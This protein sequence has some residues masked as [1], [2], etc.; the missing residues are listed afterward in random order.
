MKFSRG[1][2]ASVAAVRA[3]TGA[4]IVWDFTGPDDSADAAEEQRQQRLHEGWEHRQ[5]LLTPSA[6]LIAACALLDVY[7]RRPR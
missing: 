7:G 2:A 5:R 3:A 1:P 4:S 6:E